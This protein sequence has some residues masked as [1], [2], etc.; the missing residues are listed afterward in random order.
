MNTEDSK[1]NEPQRQRLDLRSSDK[2]FALEN[3]SIYHTWKNIRKQYKTNKLKIIALARND[4]FE[5][6]D[7]SYSVSDIKDYIEYII[8]KLERLTAIPPIHV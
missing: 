3:L 1:M 4:D 6:P 2:H 5:L 7:G 8:K